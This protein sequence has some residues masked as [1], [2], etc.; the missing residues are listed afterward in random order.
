MAFCG[1]TG[2]CVGQTCDVAIQIY[3]STRSSWFPIWRDPNAELTDLICWCSNVFWNVHRTQT[4]QSQRAGYAPL[5]H[6]ISHPN[7]PLHW[8]FFFPLL[9]FSL[10]SWHSQGNNTE[11]FYWSPWKN[12]FPFIWACV[13]VCVCRIHILYLS[14]HNVYAAPSPTLQAP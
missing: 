4:T 3:L 13:C 8:F 7:Q 6:L 14:Y 10:H 5:P 1:N 9:V 12:A 2:C 11:L